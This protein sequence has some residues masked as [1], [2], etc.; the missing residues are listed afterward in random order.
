MQTFYCK[1]H[2]YRDKNYQIRRC[3]HSAPSTHGTHL[4]RTACTQ[5][6]RHAPST[7]GTHPNASPH[8][9][10]AS[11]LPNPKETEPIWASPQPQ[12][13]FGRS[14]STRRHRGGQGQHRIRSRYQLRRRQAAF[15]AAAGRRKAR[16]MHMHAQK[17]DVDGSPIQRQ[18]GGIP[19]STDTGSMLE[20]RNPIHSTSIAPPRL[21]PSCPV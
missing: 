9:I 19:M 7:H 21:V 17:G 15:G 5:H 16:H 3:L 1:C 2:A 4:A 11:A 14:T 20:L 6:A 8:L 12:T 13:G 18:K 10:H